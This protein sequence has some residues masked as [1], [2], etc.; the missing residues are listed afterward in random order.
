MTKPSA[1]THSPAIKTAHWLTAALIAFTYVLAFSIRSA[2]S[3]EQLA[4]SLMLHRSTGVAIVVL[5]LVRLRVRTHVALPAWPADLPRWQQIATT[6]SERALYHFLLVQPAL[7]I[8][9]SVLHGDVVLFGIPVPQL[10]PRDRLLAREILAMHRGVGLSLLALIAVHVAAALHHHFIRRDDILLR[11][12]PRISARP[13][14]KARQRAG[15]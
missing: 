12:L 7:G 5:T 2:Q 6:T 14:A 4:W 3:A 8:A 9:G 1:A 13:G 11:M 10:V 15:T